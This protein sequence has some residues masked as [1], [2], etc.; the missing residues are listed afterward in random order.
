MGHVAHIHTMNVPSECEFTFTECFA[1]RK[2]GFGIWDPNSKLHKNKHQYVGPTQNQTSG[3][4]V[5]FGS[6]WAISCGLGSLLDSVG[7]VVN[8]NRQLNTQC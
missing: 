5:W 2:N 6:L 8:C 7:P 1:A 4:E 3:T